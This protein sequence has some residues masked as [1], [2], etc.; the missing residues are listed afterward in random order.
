MARAPF[1][2][3]VYPY[4]KTGDGDFEYA[5][6]KSAERN[7]WEAVAG[8]GEDQETILEAAK[9]E[10]FEETGI[11]VES[12]PIRLDTIAPVPVTRFKESALWGKDLFVIPI[13]YFGVLAPDRQI[14]ISE[15]HSEYK[16]LRYPEARDLLKFEDDKI[17]LW[18]L[19]RR[20]RGLG[21][22]D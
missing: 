10:T 16:W 4:L 11:V 8:G 19:D 20:V 7:I 15:E 18:E 6:L 9:R 1:I 13:H 3:F 17:A 14:R 22:R 12:P 21:P 5:L 2:V